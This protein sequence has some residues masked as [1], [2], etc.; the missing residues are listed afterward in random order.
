MDFRRQGQ[1]IQL[2]VKFRARLEKLY[3]R[4]LPETE[5]RKAKVVEFNQLREE[6]RRLKQEWK[7][8]SGYDGW[9]NDQLNNAKLITVSTYNDLVP[10]FLKLL[11]A[12]GD[13]KLFYNR[14]EK[15]AEKS[16]EE[17]RA[18]LQAYRGS[19]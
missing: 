3:A 8:Y 17:R 2:I 9:F 1:F 5:K 14:C 13:L 11:A 16:K 19:D 15:L 12:A 7:G 18:D 6:Y 10:A 4:D